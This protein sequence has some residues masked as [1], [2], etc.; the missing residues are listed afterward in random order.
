MP[1]FKLDIPEQKSM[2]ALQKYIYV[3]RKLRE[4]N[5]E[6]IVN[7]TEETDNI[8]H[9]E[10]VFLRLPNS[11]T[12]ATF[13][14]HRE[15]RYNGEKIDEQ[16]HLGID[17]ASVKQVEVPASNAGKVVFAE[18]LGIYGENSRHRPWVRFVQHVFTFKQ[19]QC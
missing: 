7:S 9:W 2:T 6:V 8:L 11:A 3:N 16:I 19:N 17:L 12:R 5:Y 18:S 4:A 10:G 14:D 1:E 15:Y 13:A